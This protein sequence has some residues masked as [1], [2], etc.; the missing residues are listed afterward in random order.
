MAPHALFAPDSESEFFAVG[1]ADG[2]DGEAEEEGRA[3]ETGEE[4]RGRDDEAERDEVDEAGSDESNVGVGIT[5]SIVAVGPSSS[6]SS[7]KGV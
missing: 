6:M 5:V 2:R 3:D 4:D 7:T 1:L